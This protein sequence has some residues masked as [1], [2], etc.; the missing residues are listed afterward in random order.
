MT[1]LW[2]D[3]GLTRPWN[4]ADSDFDFAIN[5]PSSTVIVGLIDGK[6]VAS[7]MVGHDGHRGVVYYVSVHPDQQRRRLGQRLMA[8]A[9]LWLTSRGVPKMNLIVRGGNDRAVEFYETLGYQVEP[10]I[11]M[12]KRLDGK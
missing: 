4:D 5:G 7:S 6:I 1:R 10:N 12:G 3:C 8:E 9:E 2:S 11:Q